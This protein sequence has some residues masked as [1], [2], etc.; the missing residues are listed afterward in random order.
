MARTATCHV[1]VKT[2]AAN[3]ARRLLRLAVRQGGLR[4]SPI[5]SRIEGRVAR[6]ACWTAAPSGWI[7][8]LSLIHISEPTR[9]A[10]I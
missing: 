9:L 3:I 6:W 1:H 5:R 10:L 8:G 7:L 2:W 4:L